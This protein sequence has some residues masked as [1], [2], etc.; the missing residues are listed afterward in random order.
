MKATIRIKYGTESESPIDLTVE[1]AK[2]VYEI[3]KQI[4]E[5]KTPI[6]NP[7]YPTYPSYPNTDYPWIHEPITITYCKSF[8]DGS[9]EMGYSDGTCY[10]LVSSKS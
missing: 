3:L 6:T 8:P 1:D 4:F 10:N 7:I 9:I 2:Q 5:D